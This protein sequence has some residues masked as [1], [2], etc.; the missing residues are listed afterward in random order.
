MLSK[1]LRIIPEIMYNYNHLYLLPSDLLSRLEF[2][3]VRDNKDYAV[4][5]YLFL[6]LIFLICDY[7]IDI[8]FIVEKEFLFI[9]L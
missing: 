9:N 5:I 6:K 1:I 7:Y 4:Y 3:T 8:F 2:P